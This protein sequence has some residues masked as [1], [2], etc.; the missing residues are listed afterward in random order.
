VL[1]GRDDIRDRDPQWTHRRTFLGGWTD[2]CNGRLYETVLT[3]K[4]HANMGNLFGWIYGRQSMDFK[5]ETWYRYC[6]KTCEREEA[7]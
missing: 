3:R 4:T 5:L 1:D 2:A 7:A 6:C